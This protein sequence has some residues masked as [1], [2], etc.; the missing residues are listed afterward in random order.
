[1]KP[2]PRPEHQDVAAF[3][4]N[5]YYEHARAG[6]APRANRHLRAL[7]RRLHLRHGQSILDVAC[8]TGDWL[9]VARGQGLDVAGVDISAKAIDICRHRMPQGR[10]SAGPAERL[11]FPDHTFDH[12]TCLG[13]LEHFL[14]QPG[15][16][17]E[18]VRVLKPGGRIVLLVP[19]AGFLPYRLGFYKGTQQQAVRETIRSLDEWRDM[20]GASGLTILDR[21]RDLHVLD[22]AWI[23]RRPWLML[24]PRLLQALLLPLWPLGW[25]YQV[26]H[27]CAAVS[28]EPADAPTPAPQAASLL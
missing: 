25:Q 10:F 18:M 28:P 21:W 2:A 23:L 22:G 20:F 6:L 17:R 19:N 4:D 5:V 16:L 15:A 11:D 8:G 26:Y 3:Y 13:S 27:L 14:D 9:C 1:M 7:A 24:V 12:V